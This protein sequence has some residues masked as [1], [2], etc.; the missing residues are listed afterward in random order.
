MRPSLFFITALAVFAM[1]FPSRLY[2]NQAF[3]D[4]AN[5]NERFVVYGLNINDYENQLLEMALKLTYADAQVTNYP[6]YLPRG[7]EFS[8]MEKSQGI[9]VT[10]GNAT[11]ARE[12]RFNG[13]RI[14]I[15]KGLIGWRLALVTKKDSN[16]FTSVKD[17]DSFRQFTA[18]QNLVWTDTKILNANNI[19]TH[20][21]SNKRTLAEMLVLQRFDYF[22]R[23]VIEIER[24]LNEFSQL[25]LAIEPH[26]LLTYPTAYYFYVSKNN[27]KLANAIEHGLKTLHASGQ[28]DQHFYAHFADLLLRL[29]LNKRTQIILNNPLL[30][31]TAPTNQTNLWLTTNDIL[32]FI[33]SSNMLAN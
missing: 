8:L 32:K 31:N 28:F 11:E 1:V 6:S 22:P 3:E 25:D 10:W 14:P 12:R 20:S 23:S 27:T 15:Y 5:S 7:R 4:H 13:I 17:L 2:A 16:L 29:N 33:P 18:G 26:I 19:V 21:G 9:D 24:D 30:P